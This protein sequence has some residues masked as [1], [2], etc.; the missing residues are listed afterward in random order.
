MI[1]IAILKTDGSTEKIQCTTDERLKTLQ[2]AVGGYIE[3]VSGVCPP[4]Y[5]CIVNEDGQ[6]LQL[7]PNP[8]LPNIVGNIALIKVE[9]ME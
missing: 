1:N 7:E 5:L 9:D 3:I 6:R 2:D 8:Y 4:D